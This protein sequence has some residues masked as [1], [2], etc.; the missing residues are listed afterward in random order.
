MNECNS[1]QGL[2]FKA[3]RADVG[4]LGCNGNRD[5]SDRPF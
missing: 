5:R 2:L 3:R 4:E 1:A